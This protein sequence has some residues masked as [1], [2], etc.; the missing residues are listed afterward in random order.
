MVHVASTNVPFTSESKDAVAN[1]PAIEDEVEL[2]LREA[3][4][5]LKSYL[6][7]K[8]SLEK[9]REKQDVIA[10]ILPEMAAKVTEVTGREPL[11]VEDS[12]ARIMNNVLV[13]H[14]HEDGETRL[15]VSNHDDRNADLEITDIL[16]TDPGEV[17][18]ATVVEMDGEWFV[19]WEPTVG[20]GDSASLTYSVP[21]DTEFDVSVEGVEGERLTIDDQ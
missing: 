13:E 1:I 17:E 9:R 15:V 20:S 21:E 2:A 19:K 8:R 7:K 6:N 11:D 5:E 14:R 18:G 10:K 16:S 3:A 4:R 12:L